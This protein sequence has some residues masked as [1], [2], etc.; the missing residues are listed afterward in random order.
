MSMLA[1]LRAVGS[2]A[3]Q[4]PNALLRQGCESRHAVAVGNTRYPVVLVHG[5]AG[6]ES[7]WEAVRCALAAAGFGHIV[8]LN[9]NSFATDPVEVS[10]TVRR[11]ALRAVEATGTGGVHLVGHSLGGIIVRHAI[12]SNASLAGLAATAVTIASPH[13]GAPL[14]RIA[15]GRCAHIMQ[16]GGASSRAHEKAMRQ[17]R[18]LAYY[19]DGDRV[20]PT[21][22]AR[23][24][25]ARYGATNLL[26]P[27]CGHLTI[28]RDARLVRSLVSE[29]IRTET[30]T[31]PS[32]LAQAL[33]PVAA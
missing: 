5:Y 13:R 10:A 24:D 16:S 18:W 7:V 33:D 1:E 17:V 12:T 31:A 23:M 14:A 2:A 20:V 15:P 30:T 3:L 4:L 26:I 19:S 28:C 29:L 21:I 32:V 8:S 27:G 22:S 9:Y 11:L 25:D 6:G